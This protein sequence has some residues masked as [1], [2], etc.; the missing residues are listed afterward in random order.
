MSQQGLG[1][2]R[3]LDRRRLARLPAWLAPWL[4]DAGS[5]TARLQQRFGGRLEVRPLTQRRVPLSLDEG[6]LLDLRRGR[7]VR[8]REVLLCVDGLPRVYARSLLPDESLRGRMYPLARL[9]QRPLGAWLFSQP[10]LLRDHMGL[11]RVPLPVVLGPECASAGPGHAWARRSRFRVAGRPILV[12]EAFL[13]ALG[14][15]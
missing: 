1:Q 7:Q 3:P 12:T 10:D 6:R 14:S 5:L 15:A 11:A 4:G 8:L 2:W 9:G 13:A